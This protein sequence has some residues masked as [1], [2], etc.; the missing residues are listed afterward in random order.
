MGVWTVFLPKGRSYAVK[1]STPATIDRDMRQQRRHGRRLALSY[2]RQKKE[3][4]YDDLKRYIEHGPPGMDLIKVFAGARQNQ[5]EFQKYVLF[6]S[7]NLHE[8][9]YVGD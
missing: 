4:Q 8:T 1:T 9:P 2:L 5:L 7:V 3:M 6:V